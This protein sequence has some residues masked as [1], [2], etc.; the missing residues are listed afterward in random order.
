MVDDGRIVPLQRLSPEPVL[1]GRHEV[2]L[3]DGFD[4]RVGPRQGSVR[5]RLVHVRAPVRLDECLRRVGEGPAVGV[6][7]QD[8][9]GA[10]RDVLDVRKERPEALPGGRFLEAVGRE[11]GGVVP[12]TGLD[13]ARV[14]AAPDFAARRQR[15]ECAGLIRGGAE[16]SRQLRD[17]VPRR[18]L[19]DRRARHEDQV[20][21][22]LPRLEA[23]GQGRRQVL[24]P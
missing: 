5:K 22:R 18:V 15:I 13:F 9:R 4:A 17:P 20:G 8:G 11:V 10:A 19:L 24:L 14:G 16:G 23:D 6:P 1:Q 3:E 12:E 21:R 7:A 2:L